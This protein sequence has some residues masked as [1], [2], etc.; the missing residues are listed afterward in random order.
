MIANFFKNSKPIKIFNITFLLFFLMVLAV[1]YNQ[2]DLFSFVIV[3]KYLGVFA[4]CILYLLIFKFVIEKNKLT[5]DNSYALFALVCVLGIFPEIFFSFN[6]IFS[7]LFLIL[8]FRKIYS[9]KSGINTKLKL[10]DAAFWIGIATLFY[11][12]NIAYLL[13]IFVAI[14]SHNK[15]TLRNMLIPIIGFATPIF[16]FFTYN[17]YIDNLS[18]FYNKFDYTLSLKFFTYNSL[19]FLMPITFLVT[20]LVGAIVF[21]TPK[22]MLVSNHLKLSWILLVNQLL[23]T[24]FIIVVAPIKNGAEFFNLAFPFSIV[25]ANYLQK[26]NSKLLKNALLYL[27][28]LLAIGIHFL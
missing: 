10:F 14:I 25:A 15:F 20:F 26:S 18:F 8:S 17:F 16:I 22:I 24:F 21:V 9:L 23:I 1:F 5:K 13:L 6:I 28:L 4:L 27:L 19:E 12:W 11:F 2:K 3:L 7:N